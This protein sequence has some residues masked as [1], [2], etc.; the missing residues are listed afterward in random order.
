MFP[1]MLRR[2]VESQYHSHYS[3]ESKRAVRVIRV[4]GRVLL[5]PMSVIITLTTHGRA[6][7][8]MPYA[9]LRYSMSRKKIVASFTCF[10]K[11]K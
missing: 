2:T 9:A 3:R 10:K 5:F 4:R 11:N 1:R 6:F 8:Q 7:L